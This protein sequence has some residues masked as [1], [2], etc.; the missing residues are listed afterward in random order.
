MAVTLTHPTRGSVELT[1]RDLSAMRAVSVGYLDIQTR[2]RV[3]LV[4]LGLASVLPDGYALTD[5]GRVALE[6]AR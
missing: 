2:D 6:V 4:F 5:S 1:D 3:R